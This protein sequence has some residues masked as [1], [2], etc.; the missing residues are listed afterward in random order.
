MN[1]TIKQFNKI[2]QNRP[3][4]FGDFYTDNITSIANWIESKDGLK[5]NYKLFDLNKQSDYISFSLVFSDTLI[6]HPLG[7]YTLKIKLPKGESFRKN[8]ETLS[9]PKDLYDD[10]NSSELLDKLL[11]GYIYCDESQ[12][13]NFY[14][15]LKQLIK[16]EKVL[17]CPD[18]IALRVLE[19]GQN[20]NANYQGIPVDSN[21][22]F[23]QWILTPNEHK[24][25]TLPLLENV[26]KPDMVRELFSLSIPFLKGLNFSDLSKVLDD[27]MDC[28]S[29]LRAHLKD[30]VIQYRDKKTL[31]EIQED[32][33]RP[34]IEK[35]TIRFKKIQGIHKLRTS[36]VILGSSAIALALYE[37][38][39]VF[40]S[41]L[42]LLGA[43]GLGLITS[44]EKYQNSIQSMKE[45]PLY[46]FWKLKS[47]K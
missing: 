25:D 5:T 26:P 34:E 21:S 40:A 6:L 36:G 12:L 8:I 4:N 16:N 20:G 14:L 1:K 29:I 41:I 39:G 46:L 38:E 44:E 24:T 13:K 43:G 35:L 11:L 19:P 32:L 47:L 45:E 42:E 33:I 23:N 17:L 31:I 30:T 3:E 27:N 18:R 9:L 7:N 28:L 22:S 37:K 15:K 10:I 2:C